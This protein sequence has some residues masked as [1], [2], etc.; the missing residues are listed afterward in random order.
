VLLCAI[1]LWGLLYRTRGRK[2]FPTQ[3]KQPKNADDKLRSNNNGNVP[4]NSSVQVLFSKSSS[5]S[6]SLL[7]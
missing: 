1:L 4:E 3:T 2:S 5:E 6:Q 7:D